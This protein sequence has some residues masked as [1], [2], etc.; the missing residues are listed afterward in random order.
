MTA[1]RVPRVSPPRNS[2]PYPDPVIPQPVT[3][4]GYPNPCH[5]LIAPATLIT[6]A[7]HYAALL[8]LATHYAALLALA[9]AHHECGSSAGQH[10]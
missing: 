9:R 10:R 8:T 7:M 3:L 5:C 1:P 2:N 6:L 4:R